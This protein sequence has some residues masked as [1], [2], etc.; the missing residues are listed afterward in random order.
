MYHLGSGDLS[1][2]IDFVGL[3]EVYIL[4]IHHQLTD[5]RTIVTDLLG[6]LPRIDTG[7]PDH[8]MALESI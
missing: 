1:D 8:A 2:K 6:E 4:I 5:E 7:E 3:E